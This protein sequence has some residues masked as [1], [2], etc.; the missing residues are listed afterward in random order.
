M[1]A[2]HEA[3]RSYRKTMVAALAAG[4]AV[5]AATVV[6]QAF[7]SAK[8]PILAVRLLAVLGW[9]AGSLFLIGAAGGVLVAFRHRRRESGDEDLF[10]ALNKSRS[11]ASLLHD[12][13]STH[14]AL[15]GLRRLFG[16]PR[17]IVGDVVRIRS[18]HEVTA[19]LD[20]QGCLD[21]LPFMP[22]MTQYCG[23]TGTVFRCVDKIYDYGGRKD[24]R[25]LAN[26]VSI[27]GL[28][29]DGAAH[30][31]CQ[32]KCYLLWKTAWLEDASRSAPSA[33]R[34]TGTAGIGDAADDRHAGRSARV[35]VSEGAAADRKYIC[36]FTR[37][38]GATSEMR[39][40]DPR[41]DLRP[42]IAG[43]VTAAAFIVAMLTRLF[44]LMQALRGGIGYPPIGRSTREHSE[45]ANHSLQPG[46][47]VRVRD[48][49][50]IFDTLDKSGRNRG[51]W[52]DRGML[53]YTKCRY[54][55]L[56]R[57]DRV[58]DDASGRM[59]RMKTPCVTLDGVDA[60]GEYMRFCAQH[61]Y[62]FWREIWLERVEHGGQPEADTSARRS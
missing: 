27:A 60:C 26:T 3:G 22:E 51:L 21:G 2:M 29:C 36:Q 32:A 39:S 41:Q 31:D 62:P 6:A 16:A 47:W 30:G 25:R 44:N 8:A 56:A 9:V 46:E 48:A 55:V 61:D 28:R 13:G 45:Q 34:R 35:S 38:V 12:G 57:V 11:E 53:K 37:L 42:L 50:D 20:A 15:S 14:R 10:L 43:N 52:F 40:W 54:R 59:I 17:F 24:M 19:T 1:Y 18:L 5:I 7:A 23:T 4:L 58:I 33:G 49:Q